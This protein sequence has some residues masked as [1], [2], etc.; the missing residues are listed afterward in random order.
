MTKE[1][2]WIRSYGK[3]KVKFDVKVINSDHIHFAIFKVK[4]MLFFE[5]GLLFRN[6]P[7]LRK[8]VS[9]L[10]KELEEKHKKKFIE[11]V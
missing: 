6:F 7:E 8:E 10:K 4:G 11:L 3:E 1:V 5:L 9:N 2:Y